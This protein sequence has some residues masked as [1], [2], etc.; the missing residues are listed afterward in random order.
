M[1]ETTPN[2]GRC[3]K[4][5]KEGHFHLFYTPF[6]CL[7]FVFYFNPHP[8]ICLLILERDGE[9]GKGVERE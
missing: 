8:K 7:N 6:Y 1:K 4:K 3:F 9:E 5:Q 2:H